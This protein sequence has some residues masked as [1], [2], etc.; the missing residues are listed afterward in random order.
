MSHTYYMPLK[1]A[2]YKSLITDQGSKV[3][4]SE[5]ERSIGFIP[6]YASIEDCQAAWPDTDV[7]QVE[8]DSDI[9]VSA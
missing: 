3:R 6:L 1:V 2:T 8:A 5:Q 4:P 9:E 7:M